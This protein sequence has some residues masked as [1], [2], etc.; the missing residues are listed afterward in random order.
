MIA[1][2]LLQIG[3]GLIA[4][5]KH[6]QYGY[7]HNHQ[8]QRVAKGSRKRLQE[9]EVEIAAVEQGGEYGG[10]NAEGDHVAQYAANGID[11]GMLNGEYA[12]LYVGAVNR[13]QA[14]AERHHGIAHGPI[15]PQ[16]PAA[17]KV[18]NHVAHAAAYHCG[19]RPEQRAH[20]NGNYHGGGKA[21]VGEYG[22]AA[23][24]HQHAKER[25]AYGNGNYG[26]GVPFAQEHSAHVLLLDFHV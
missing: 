1:L 2:V 5:G 17:D 18:G 9:G 26:L 10:N 20:Y 13:Q 15:E 3:T 12:F 8:H 19:Q 21:G 14:N 22:Y 7:A 23:V 6:Q 11:N 16:A 24:A 4:V 25:R